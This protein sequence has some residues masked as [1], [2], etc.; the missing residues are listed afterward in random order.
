M[1]TNDPISRARATLDGP[2]ASPSEYAR[3]QLRVVVA[4]YDHLTAASTTEVAPPPEAAAPPAPTPR[5][6]KR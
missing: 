1:G 6:R 3:E 4:L 2:L 5:R